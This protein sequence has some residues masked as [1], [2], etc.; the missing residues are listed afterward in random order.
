MYCKYTLRQHLD[1]LNSYY[2]NI[3]E[4]EGIDYVRRVI[5]SNN[6]S[7]RIN[8]LKEYLNIPYSKPKKKTISSIL[9]SNFKYIKEE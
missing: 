8:R 3:I 7:K 4:Y 5:I 6:I 2:N 9:N 1:T